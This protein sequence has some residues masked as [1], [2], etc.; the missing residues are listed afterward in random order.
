MRSLGDDYVRAEFKRHKDAEKQ[1]IP[2][3][4]HEWTVSF[5]ILVVIRYIIIRIKCRK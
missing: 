1:F 3:F 4:M 5:V 2:L